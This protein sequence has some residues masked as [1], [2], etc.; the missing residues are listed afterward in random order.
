M[1]KFLFNV[2]CYSSLIFFIQGCTA[3]NNQI[4]TPQENKKTKIEEKAQN[5]QNLQKDSQKEEKQITSKKETEKSEK[6][7]KTKEE[8]P[9]EKVKIIIKK[10]EIPVKSNKII[11]GQKELVYIP[12]EDIT[13]KARIDTGATTTSINAL[14]IKEVE[15]DGKKWVKFDLKDEKEKLITKSLPISRI[16]KIK[17]HGTDVQ[18]RYVVKMKLTIGNLTQFIDV[19]LTDRTKFKYPVLIGRNFLNGLVLVDVSKEY[20]IN[21]KKN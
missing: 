9:K 13:L 21:P 14:N 11:I 2:I 6:I 7:K 4:K 18:E 3:T 5:P 20:T 15:R 1:K 19:S 10:V 16:V 12:S 8:K 17:R